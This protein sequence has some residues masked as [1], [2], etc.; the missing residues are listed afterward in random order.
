MMR[1]LYAGVSGLKNHQTRMD[2]I[3]NNIS[4]V[5]TYGFKSE[6]VTFQDM[7]SQTMSG[8]AAPQENK[9]GVNPK[10]VGLGM[11]IASIDKIFTQGS[12]QTTGKETDLA[13]T[14]DGLFIL[15]DGDK[16]FYT[17]AG[18]FNIDRDGTLVNPGNGMKVEGWMARREADGA[19]SINTSTEEE[20]ITLPIY[21]KDPARRTENVKFLCNLNS[22]AKILDTNATTEQISKHG[23]A[24]RINVFDNLGNPYELNV[25]FWRTGTNAWLA[26]S[27]LNGAGSVR[28]DIVNQAGGPNQENTNARIRLEFS[29]EGRLIAAGDDGTPDRINRGDL[30]VNLSFQFPNEPVRRNIQL[31]LGQVGRIDKSITQFSSEF[32]T[33]MSEQDGYTLGYMESF[34]IGDSGRITGVYSNGQNRTLGQI[35][36]AVFTNPA[37]LTKAGE[38]R[39]QVSN[40]SGNPQVGAAGVQGRGKINA[41]MLEM[42]NV[43]LSDAFTDM[44]VTQRGFQ[45]NSRTITTSD[46]MLQELLGL[47]R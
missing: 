15:R 41:G 28:A 7:L 31:D 6:R 19:F 32:T 14:G 40:N 25:R 34:K 27:S 37:G 16:K 44:I 9:G 45:A 29:P 30:N 42:S 8:A 17:R 43:D 23:W 33:K 39:F 35:A 10:Q 12:L 26:E 18:T 13:I 47:K 36:L 3:G 20:D 46:Q 22:K 38:S 11:M 4:N 5:N 1:S 2:V 21:G 24:T